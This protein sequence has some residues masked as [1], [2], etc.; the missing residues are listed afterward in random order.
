[1]ASEE[2]TQELTE[3]EKLLAAR[4][5]YA[6]WAWERLHPGVNDES[7]IKKMAAREAR[8]HLLGVGGDYNSAL[9]RFRSTVQWRKVRSK[10]D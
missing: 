6:F 3:E 8:R 9:E 2:L 1:M 7:I 10:Y 5:S 4:T